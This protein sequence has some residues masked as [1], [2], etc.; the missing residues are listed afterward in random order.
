MGWT[1]YWGYEYGHWSS[2]WSDESWNSSQQ[3]QW[4]QY[5]W[6]QS[7]SPNDVN[8]K[9]LPYDHGTTVLPNDLP[10][11]GSG[12]GPANPKKS[13]G[14]DDNGEPDSDGSQW[15][16]PH[17]LMKAEVDYRLRSLLIT[18]L[19][20]EYVLA[21]LP[22]DSNERNPDQKMDYVDRPIVNKEIKCWGKAM[23]LKDHKDILVKLQAKAVNEVK[24][25]PIQPGTLEFAF[26]KGFLSA[27]RETERKIPGSLH[28]SNPC[29]CL[30]TMF[31]KGCTHKGSLVAPWAKTAR[32]SMCK[33]CSKCMRCGRL[34]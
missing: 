9:A 3:Y 22:E 26:A 20:Y 6:N 31:L 2:Y 24:G 29:Y 13:N 32:D 5:Q 30:P 19:E 1:W 28:E 21:H 10:L 18:P 25:S 34:L 14:S 27:S 16:T 12:P 33:N 7:S 4:K 17:A 11:D 15:T 23:R 8:D